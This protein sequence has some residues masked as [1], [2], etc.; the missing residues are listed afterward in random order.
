[1]AR[2]GRTT[3]LRPLASL[4][5]Y[6]TAALLNLALVSTIPHTDD[7]PPAAHVRIV[8]NGRRFRDTELVRLGDGSVGVASVPYRV[9]EAE[10][11]IGKN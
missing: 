7:R 6:V 2:P 11:Q 9:W 1:M 10:G 5:T 3:P 8:T 4:R